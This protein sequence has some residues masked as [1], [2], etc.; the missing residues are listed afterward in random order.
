MLKLLDV[1][2]VIY[3]KLNHYYYL[4]KNFT[5]LCRIDVSV[6]VLT[7]TS[8]ILCLEMG[9][10]NYTNANVILNLHTLEDSI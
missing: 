2:I 10:L 8:D 9:M 4:L 5:S 6:G 1:V 7:G 3:F